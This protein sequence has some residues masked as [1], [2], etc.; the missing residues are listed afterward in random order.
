MRAWVKSPSIQR[1]KYLVAAKQE[2]FFL[3]AQTVHRVN[4]GGIL[5]AVAEGNEG[6]PL[7]SCALAAFL[8][9]RPKARAVGPGLARAGR[10]DE[11]GRIRLLGRIP[12]RGSRRAGGQG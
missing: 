7:V 8:A 5:D 2:D 11:R 6:L 10:S 9:V 4:G 1:V 3:L 12:T